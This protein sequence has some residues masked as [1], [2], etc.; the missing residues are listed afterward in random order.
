MKLIGINLNYKTIIVT[1]III[2]VGYLLWSYHQSRIDEMKQMINEEVKLRNALNDEIKTYQNERDEWVN[3]KLTLQTSLENL[4]DVYS[5]LTGNQ[6]ELV[7]RLNNVQKNQKTIAAALV[8][9][10]VSIDNLIHDGETEV[11]DDEN[12]VEFS[13]INDNIEYRFLIGEVNRAFPNVEPTLN[14]K[15]LRIPNKQEVN[16]YWEDDKKEGY[17]TSFKITNSNPFIEISNMESYMIPEIRKDDILP[18]NWGKIK[19]WTKD[20]GD[21]LIIISGVSLISIGIGALV[22]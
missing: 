8:D 2:L 9:V 22:F 6:K 5:S 21:R 11:N 1:G 10:E 17:P 19:T 3:E 20:N 14:I 7:D 4:M 18:S 15:T 16:F 13:N 12:T